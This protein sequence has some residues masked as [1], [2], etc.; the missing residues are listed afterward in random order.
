VTRGQ[1]AQCLVAALVGSGL[2]AGAMTAVGGGSSTRE[3]GLLASSSAVEQ[4]SADEIYDRAAPSVVHIRARSVQPGASPFAARAQPVQGISTGSGFVLDQEGHIVTNAH[5]VSGVTD[6]QVT[7]ADLRTVPARVVGK[8]EETDLAVLRVEPEGL[9]LRPLELGD[10]DEVRAGDRAVAIGNPSGLETT[11]GTGVVSAASEQLETPGGLVLDGII[12]TD[13][14]I[15]PGTSGGPLIAADG[16]VIGV[17]SQIQ[18]SEPSVGFAVPAN[19]AKD[20]LAQL[21]ESH[22]LIRPYL[23][24]RGR[25]I[26][27][28]QPAPDGDGTSG[29][30][31]LDVYDGSPAQQAGLRGEE[32]GSDVIEAVDGRP[33]RTLDE[34][35]DEIERKEPGDEIELGVLRDGSRST[36]EVRLAERPATLPAG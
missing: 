7:F 16:R 12:R 21:E 15:E 10:S 26:D 33:V 17:T 6:V 35:L 27:A 36:V 18:G 20:V 24:V 28:A 34:M 1:L 13:A 23:G 22:K 14:V 29:V 32:A 11:A 19:T 2:T 9:D 25:S 3:S 4:L 8:D 31:V 30:L 5:V